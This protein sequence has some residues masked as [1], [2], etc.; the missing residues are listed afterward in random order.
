MTSA[1]IFVGAVM[2]VAL[3]GVGLAI[4]GLAY[5]YSMDAIGRSESGRQGCRR[6]A[7]GKECANCSRSAE[8]DREALLR[9]WRET[10]WIDTD[11]VRRYSR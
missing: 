4:V 8:P 10:G 5:V 2:G 9:V 1:A 11:T 7:G 3:G 6:E